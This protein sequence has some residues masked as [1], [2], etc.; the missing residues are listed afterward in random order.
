VGV[1]RAL[2]QSRRLGRRRAVAW[3]RPA[4]LFGVLAL[5]S[6]A[7]VP[8]FAAASS[9]APP[10]QSPPAEVAPP[11]GSGS[12]TPAATPQPVPSS[13]YP[14]GTGGRVYDENCAGCHGARGEGLVGPPLAAAGF[15]GLVGPMV[16]EGGISMPG[17]AGVLSDQDV[18]AVSDF[19]ADE[20]ADPESRTAEVSPGGDLFRL[21]CSGCHSSTGSGGAMPNLNNAP[22]IRKYPPA[23]AIAA[24]I[25]GRGNMPSFAGNTFD[26]RQQ[27]SVALYVQV[28]DDPPSPGGA[29][30]GFLGPVPEGAVGGIALFVLILIAVWLAWPTRKAVP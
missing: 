7:A 10:L 19:V 5:V 17:F 8:A 24:M 6:A 1:S 16:V 23:E 26:V 18:D 12:F 11:E 20:L 30:L 22:N 9:P 15:A 13:T 29:G 4:V 27:T 25:L 3:L 14:A 21:Y 28:L 2:V